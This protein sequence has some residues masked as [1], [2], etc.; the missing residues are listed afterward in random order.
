MVRNWIKT[1]KVVYP[2]VRGKEM[3]GYTDD[4]VSIGADFI[5]QKFEGIY[6][7]PKYAGTLRFS[8]GRCRNFVGS[9]LDGL[10]RCCTTSNL[11]PLLTLA[12]NCQR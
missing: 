2:K 1:C 12:H 9:A 11:N 4:L 3:L 8:A 7:A 5:L 10:D 6:S